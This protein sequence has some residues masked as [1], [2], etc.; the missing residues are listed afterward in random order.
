MNILQTKPPHI[1]VPSPPKDKHER[2]RLQSGSIPEHFCLRIKRC[3]EQ[4]TD[5]VALGRIVHP[6][7][8]GKAGTHRRSGFLFNP[9][10]TPE[11][12]S[13]QLLA[14]LYHGREGTPALQCLCLSHL[15]FVA[16]RQFLPAASATT[17]QHLATILGRHARTKPMRVFPLPVVRLKCNTHR[18]SLPRWFKFSTLA[19]VFRG[20]PFR[21]QQSY[22]KYA[23][24]TTNA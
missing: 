12:P 23:T 10:E 3:P 24:L 7:G 4:A 1:F 15:P 22:K 5:P 19:P 20:V 13:I 16:D 9:K 11:Q 8:N 21:G 17:G 6:A 14:T 2:Q 18:Q